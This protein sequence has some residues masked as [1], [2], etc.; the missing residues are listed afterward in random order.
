MD[1]PMNES[2]WHKCKEPF[3]PRRTVDGGWTSAFGQTW[4]RRREDG[5][6]EYKQDVET[7]EEFEDRSM[8]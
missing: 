6:W 4:R 3:F 8:F 1:L 5:R 7:L 2:L